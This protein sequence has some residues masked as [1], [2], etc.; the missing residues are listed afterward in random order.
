MSSISEADCQF[1]RYLAQPHRLE[2]RV[3][4]S[5]TPLLYFPDL[6]RDLEDGTVEIL[7]VTYLSHVDDRAERLIEAVRNAVFL[8]RA[9]NEA[10]DFVVRQ[11]LLLVQPLTGLDPVP[12]RCRKPRTPFNPSRRRP[13]AGRRLL[14]FNTKI[15]I[16]EILRHAVAYDM[17]A[18]FEMA[19]SA[20]S[21]IGLAA[22]SRVTQS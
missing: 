6:R 7:E 15:R 18:E 13:N 17:T 2:I 8:V 10:L 20:C 11:R 1:V 16:A 14:Q 19:N 5:D 3:E 4:H 12:S 22:K 21:S 9:F